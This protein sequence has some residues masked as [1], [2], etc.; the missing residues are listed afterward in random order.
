M[1]KQI[2]LPLTLLAACATQVADA[3]ESEAGKW[4]TTIRIGTELVPHGNFQG[5]HTGTIANAGT[6]NPALAGRSGVVHLDTVTY[7][8]LFR[9]G[10]S[11]DIE[12]AYRL[13][14]K[15]EPYARLSYSQLRGEAHAHIGEIYVEGQTTPSSVRAKIDDMNSWAFGVGARY[16]FVESGPLKSY[17]GGNIGVNR[18]DKLH[19][20]VRV[21]NHLAPASRRV[22]LP[23]ESR[24]NAGIELGV[25]YELAERTELRFSIG[26]DYRNARHEDSRAYEGV[27]IS[28]VRVS[29]QQ[30]F[31]PIDLG[32]N[33][34]F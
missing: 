32:L 24:F 30:W 22:L 26:A 19:G 28:T 33:I 14:D 11:A 10:P 18:A 12:L 9:V 17:V 15:L 7:D 20:H 29:D 8:D 6:F 5:R 3:R 31:L 4:S 21:D 13:T 16:F 27:G 25:S 1:I 23:D 34:K 2:S